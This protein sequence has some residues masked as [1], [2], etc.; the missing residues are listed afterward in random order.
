[1]KKIL[2]SLAIIGVIAGV[3][4]GMTWAQWTAQTEVTGSTIMSGNADL[5]VKASH[6][7]TWGNYPT[8]FLGTG[9]IYP[10][11]STIHEVDIRNSS[12]ADIAMALTAHLVIPA[13]TSDADLREALYMRIY[14]DENIDEKKSMEDWR[15]EGGKEYMGVLS[16]GEEKTLKI[17][18]SFPLGG[19]QDHLQNAEIEDF[20]LIFDGEQVTEVMNVRSQRKSSSIQTVINSSQTIPGDTIIV[21]AGVYEENVVIDKDGITLIAVSGSNVT[22]I[23]AEGGGDEG[24]VGIKANDVT[25][26]GFTVD[27]LNP[28]LSQDYQ[29]GRAVRVH[30]STD[31]VMIRNN[32]LVN[33]FRGVQGNWS[34]GG[35]NLSIINNVFETAYGIA[36]TEDMTDLVIRDN[37]FKTTTEGIGLGINITDHAVIEGNYFYDTVGVDGWYIADYGYNTKAE[38]EALLCPT[39]DFEAVVEYK[40]GVSDGERA[41][42]N[43]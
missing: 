37:T 43:Q 10:G 8:N 19:N 31:G 4:G 2:L 22:T 25:F 41:I 17:E 26:D 9:D 16:S 32:I 40:H 29:D 6:Y 35:S 36:G 11:W 42:V 3:V 21:P 39:N 1:M 14:D 24:V 28:D 18:F 27:A 5:E 38:V 33:S 20:D 7:Q 34:S 30:D 12:S 15:D 13:A 23:K